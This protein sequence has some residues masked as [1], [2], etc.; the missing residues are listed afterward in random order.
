MTVQDTDP[1]KDSPE[2]FEKKGKLTEY[3]ESAQKFIH[4]LRTAK[5]PARVDL[6]GRMGLFIPAF[7][8]VCIIVLILTM[9]W[10]ESTPI[11]L[12][13]EY[14][15]GIIFDTRWNHSKDAFGIA[16]FIVGSLMCSSLAII[17]AVPLGIG[18][19]IFLSEFCPD[20]L[21][22]PLRM[23]VEMMAAIPSIVYGLWAF[24]TLRF[25][26]ADL[27]PA[28][29]S[30]PITAWMPWFQGSTS[31][32][33]SVLSGGLILAIM[34]LPTVVAVSEDALQSVPR[35]FREASLALGA[36]K[37]ETARKVV[38]SAALPGVGAAVVLSL[39]RAIGE[40]MAVLMVTGNALNIPYTLFDPTYVMTS[41]ITV[42][43]GVT[44]S[45]PLWRAALFTIGLVLLAMSICFTLIA[46]VFVRWGMRT[47]GME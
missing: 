40:T 6:F 42:Q 45:E 35:T 32:G 46:K 4:E 34:L 9:L 1:Y 26:V 17:I 25:A 19:A 8:G 13:P 3:K 31:S 47:R 12:N 30:N 43:L 38:L 14:G 33:L 2:E 41:I 39:G 23:I 22:T 15:P 10:I 18:G 7:M 16:I 20:W 21:R 27:A 5:G 36:T 11:I 29:Q 44:A 37:S 28:L 24:T